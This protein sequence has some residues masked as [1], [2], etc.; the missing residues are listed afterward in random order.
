MDEC[1]AFPLFSSP[2]FPVEVQ[3][4]CWQHA[5]NSAASRTVTIRYTPPKTTNYSNTSLYT[6][7]SPIPALLHA[8]SRSRALALK[9]WRLAFAYQTEVPKV[10]FDFQNDNL[11][12]G[13]HF[14]NMGLFHT[15]D[16]KEVKRVALSF[17]VQVREVR[18]DLSMA[19]ARLLAKM[20]FSEFPALD[21]LGLVTAVGFNESSDR[22]ELVEI[23]PS[24]P[25]D[26]DAALI[27]RS[28]TPKE[29]VLDISLLKLQI[30]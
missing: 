14:V 30:S 15:D 23:E 22:G 10:F 29:R 16:R 28:L 8:C 27:K 6:S 7:A 1:Q 9:R 11:F 20:L 18:G 26:M 3:D 2:H 24:E 5:I 25:D 17:R 4:L 21:H 13:R 19:S 12:F